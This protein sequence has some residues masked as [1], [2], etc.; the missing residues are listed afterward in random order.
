MPTT[1]TKV[2]SL[3]ER[4]GSGI[5]FHAERTSAV[6]RSDAGFR[7]Q[8]E[9]VSSRTSRSLLTHSAL[10]AQFAGMLVDGTTYKRCHLG[11]S[12][13]CRGPISSRRTSAR[14]SPPALALAAAS[15]CRAPGNPSKRRCRGQLTRS[16]SVNQIVPP[17]RRPQ[18]ALCRTYTVQRSA[19]RRRKF[20]KMRKTTMA[21]TSVKTPRAIASR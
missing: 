19:A 15:C 3:G 12:L 11:L 20:S 7:G 16:N 2:H 14:P 1:S 21:A 4:Q 6:V 5:A 8:S 18:A 17:A 13:T 9:N 10:R